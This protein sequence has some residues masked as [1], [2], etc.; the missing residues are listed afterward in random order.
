MEDPCDFVWTQASGYMVAHQL[1]RAEVIEA[2]GW[3]LAEFDQPPI[4]RGYEALE[5]WLAS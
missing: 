2:V 1:S 5:A 3:Q 4:S